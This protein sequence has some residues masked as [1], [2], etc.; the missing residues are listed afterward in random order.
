MLLAYGDVNV[1]TLGIA[2]RRDQHANVLAGHRFGNLAR[3]IATHPGDIDDVALG[4]AG[5]R[6]RAFCNDCWG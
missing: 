3:E 6:S 2:A 1:L 4:L 5:V